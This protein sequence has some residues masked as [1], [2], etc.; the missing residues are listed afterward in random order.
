MYKAFS[1]A[2]QEP[3]AQNYVF[4]FVEHVVY[5]CGGVCFVISLSESDHGVSVFCCSVAYNSGSQALYASLSD[6]TV[7]MWHTDRET[8]LTYA[9]QFLPVL[10][11]SQPALST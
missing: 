1:I 6:G 7:I 4:F 3:S 8:A 5:V 10:H 2:E 11:Q 9:S